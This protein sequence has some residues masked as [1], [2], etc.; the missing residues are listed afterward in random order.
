MPEMKPRTKAP[1]DEQLDEPLTGELAVYEKVGFFQRSVNDNHKNTPPYCV[2]NN[3]Y[4]S[5]P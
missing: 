2:K 5:P 3:C 4:R 1:R